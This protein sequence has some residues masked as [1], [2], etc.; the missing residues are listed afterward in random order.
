M[1]HRILILLV[2]LWLG[3]GPVIAEPFLPQNPEQVLERLPPGTGTIALR[4]LRQQQLALSRRPDDLERATALAW[5][6]I[7]LGRQQADP[8]YYGHAQAALAPW[9]SQP[10]PPAEVLLLRATLHQNRHRFTE[11]LAD[12]KQ[13]LEQRPRNAQAWATRAVVLG[14]LGRP[15]AALQSCLPLTRLA[16][17]LLAVTCAGNALALQ[18]E[19]DKAYRL[20]AE[21]LAVAARA[22]V[23]ERQWALTLLAEI[24]WR[25]G[26]MEIA[27]AHYR[28][29]LDLPQRDI[30]LLAGYADLLLDQRR[31]DAVLELLAGETAADPLLLRLALAARR[32]GREDATRLTRMMRERIEAFERRGGAGYLADAARFRLELEDDPGAALALAR[33]NWANQH[34]PAAARLLLEAALAADAPRQAEP[35]QD[36]LL[37]TGFRDRHLQGLIRTLTE[38]VS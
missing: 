7:R 33:R 23:E 17:R 13:L 34:D 16:D 1:N 9:W 10:H 6:W 3:A 5:R 2:G 38:D 31:P 4:E 36:W 8:R 27:E 25:Q 30:Y 21:T 26:R 37:R 14:V 32:S 28:A 18:G 20:I 22:P 19:G 24:A 35:V 12:L 11:A 15:Q 29:A